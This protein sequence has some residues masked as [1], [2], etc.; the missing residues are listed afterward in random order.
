LDFPHIT[1]AGGA[2][3]EE[4]AVFALGVGEGA[5]GLAVEL[6]ERV[7]FVE[8]GG[9]PG[10]RDKTHEAFF[11][12]GG[13]S[14][15]NDAE[16]LRYAKVMAVDAECSAA[17]CGKIDD[18]SAGLGAYSGKLFE[19]GANLVST[20]FS[21]E[22]ESKRAVACGDAL[23]GLFELWGFLLGKGDDGDGS[24]ELGDRCVAN[25]LPVARTSIERAFE[26]AHDLVGYG[27]LGAGRE[28]RVDELGEWV[29]ELAWLGLAVIAEE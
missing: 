4:G 3:L 1:L 24:L 7:V 14:A 10:F 17:E 23:E 19:P 8:H 5:E 29:P 13:V 11:G 28:K 26:V 12:G 20:V 21:E 27:S 2:E 18:G 6:D 22:V 25:R 16:T 15:W 9:V